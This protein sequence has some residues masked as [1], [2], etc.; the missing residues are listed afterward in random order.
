MLKT[1]FKGKDFKE[2]IEASI[3]FEK[4]LEIFKTISNCKPHITM[5]IGKEYY[6]IEIRI[7]NE[8]N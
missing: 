2:W 5:F 3:E 7:E 6:G 4:K 1:N 8:K